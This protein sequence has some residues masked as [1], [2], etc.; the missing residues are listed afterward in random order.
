MEQKI[1]YTSA[2]DAATSGTDKQQM[3][4]M[5]SYKHVGKATHHFALRDLQNFPNK[6]IGGKLVS[7]PLAACSSA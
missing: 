6:A 3:L 4:T 7:I 2:K 1:R 5:S